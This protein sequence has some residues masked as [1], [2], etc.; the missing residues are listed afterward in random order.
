MGQGPDCPIGAGHSDIRG[1]RMPVNAGPVTGVLLIMTTQP[2]LAGGAQQLLARLLLRVTAAGLLIASA[3]VHLDLYATGYRT[4]RQ[5][6]G[7]FCFK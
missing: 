2:R 5:S 6:A 4:I 1:P 3:G 7:C